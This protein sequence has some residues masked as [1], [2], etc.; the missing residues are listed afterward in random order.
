M[1][2]RVILSGRLGK[3]PETNFTQGGTARTRFSIATTERYS[4]NQGEP[5][6]DTDWHNIVVWGKRGEHVAKYLRKG[7][8]AIVEGKLKTDSWDDPNGNGKRYLTYVRADNVEFGPKSDGGGGSRNGGDNG[9]GRRG[10]DS[11]NDDRRGGGNDGGGMNNDNAG[12]QGED[13]IPF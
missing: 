13:D 1:T 12:Y 8:F 4:N 7:S 2:N 5:Q 6:T 9:G 11:Y 3:D 10:H